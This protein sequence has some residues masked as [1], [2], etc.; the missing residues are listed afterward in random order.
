MSK[1]LTQEEI[2]ALLSSEQALDGSIPEPE[3]QQELR[4]YDFKRPDRISR[5]QSKTLRNI[6]DNF[7]KLLSTYLSNILRTMVDVKSPTI[8]QI[9]YIEFTMSASDF[10]NMFIFEIEH[11]EGKALLE[12]DPNFT[13]FL[14]DRLFGGPGSTNRKSN[15]ITEIESFVLKKVA[16][17]ILDYFQESWANIADLVPK[18]HQFETNPQLV[19]IAPSS[20]TMIVI[21]FPIL[22]RNFEF[23]MLLCF[24]YFMLEPI[25]K[26][27]L[28]QNFLLMLKKTPSNADI[29]LIHKV[30][31]QTNA[32]M[33]VELGKTEM[34][35]EDFVSLKEGDIIVLDRKIDEYLVG[36]IEKIPK[37]L[38]SAGKTLKNKAFRLEY[39][40]DN[41]GDIIKG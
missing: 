36:Y 18:I 27:L 31:E 1:L 5:D 19:T 16:G 8:E 12:I 23:S 33:T 2:D 28:D 40:L 39:F 20:E 30:I 29:E 10:T 4:L 35:V 9:S 17:S 24:P 14:I 37:F 38:G 7:A 25:L 22:T 34:S 15:N 21:S 32:K 41:D 6:H 3:K 26:K 11:L 13:F